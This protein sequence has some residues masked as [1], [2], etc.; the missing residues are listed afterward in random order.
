MEKRSGAARE[1]VEE[2]R[3]PGTTTISVTATEVEI[4]RQANIQ[5]EEPPY[6]TPF[7]FSDDGGLKCAILTLTI[8]DI[9]SFMKGHILIFNSINIIQNQCKIVTETNL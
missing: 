2:P 3:S 8:L 7:F 6:D 9:V 5:P 4:E 1:D